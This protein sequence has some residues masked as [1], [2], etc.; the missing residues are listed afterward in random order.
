M[1]TLRVYGEGEIVLEK[2]LLKLGKV[3]SKM[4][5]TAT[6][7]K[8]TKAYMHCGKAIIR[9]K[10]WDPEQHIADGVIPPFGQVIK[11]QAGVPA[12]QEE[13]QEIVDQAYQEHLY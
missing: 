1:E 6:L 4:P 7:V 13:V 11:E 2:E 3:G 12:T 5:A 8:V 10:L 9:S